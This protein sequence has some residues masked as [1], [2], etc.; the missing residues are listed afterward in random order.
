M[1]LW[2]SMGTHIICFVQDNTGSGLGRDGFR[3]SL[4]G[5]GGTHPQ[6]LQVRQGRKIILLAERR[7]AFT[8]PLYP[9]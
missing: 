4:S 9:L 7:Q 1:R 5:Q 2:V 3:G 6:K 8:C